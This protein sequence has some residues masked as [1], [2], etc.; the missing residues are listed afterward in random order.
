MDV[1]ALLGKL[2][3]ETKV[4]MLSG[5]DM[6]SLPEIP[7]IGLRRLVMS[8]GPIGVRG[9]AW[10]GEPSTTLPNPTALAATWD[11]ALAHRVGRLLAAEALAKGVH[12]LLA[13]TVNLH[14]SPLG[15][16]HFECYS[17]DPLLTGEIGAAFVTGVQSG[18]VAAAV[19]HFVANDSETERMTYDVRVSDRALRELYLAPFERIVR[20]GAWAVMAS[21][22]G[23]RGATLT[24]NAP[25]LRDIL[26]GEWG[27]DG[28][29]V[30]DW[31]ATRDTVRA[32]L[33]GLDIAMPGPHTVW[34]PALVAAVR[35]GRVPEST[36][37]DS[38]R[39]VLRLAERA[40]A[41]TP[42]QPE[43][44]SA[45][46]PAALAR[47]VAARSFVL[48]RNTGVLPIAT[49]TSR[50][51]VIGVPAAHPRFQ[52]GGS[53][54]LT[55]PYVVTPLDGLR[56][57]LPQADIQYVP[58]PDPSRA[59]PPAT[60]EFIVRY[61]A[62]DGTELHRASLLEASVLHI[63]DLPVESAKLAKV[64]VSGT[65]RAEMAGQW[66]VCARG[67]GQ[68]RLTVGE[69]V[70]DLTL[71]PTGGD[72]VEAF[73]LPPQEVVAVELTAR[74]SVPVE[75]ETDYVELMPG[76]PALAFTLGFASPERP[77]DELIA[78]A[79]A[80]ASAADVAIV[81]VGTTAENE[82]EGIDRA[83]ITLPGA[84]DALVA[85]VA[86][87]NPR[88]V[89]VVNAGAP[90]LV[91]WADDVAAV[92]LSWFGGQEFG[93]AL[94][95]TLTG[96]VEPGGR[97]PTTWPS[98]DAD[99]AVVTPVDGRLQ[100]TEDLAIGYRADPTAVAFP[101]GHGLGYTTW[102][103][104]D[105]HAEGDTF[106]VRL[107]NDGDRPGREIVQVYLS[108]DSGDGPTRW[109]AGFAAVTAEPGQTATATIELPERAFQIWTDAGW[110]RPEATYTVHI[111]HSVADSRVTVG[112]SPDE[113][114]EVRVGEPKARE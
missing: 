22:N 107:R 80:A 109:L 30:S 44:I 28:A 14:R 67:V 32:A 20:A 15:G 47:E 63:G 7:E 105:A 45:E 112:L 43:P 88:T 86:A 95:D 55:P 35:D 75:L 104:L 96:A 90:V 34:G 26:K 6:W 97:L 72:L 92:L 61:L 91:P 5:A 68:Y 11:P 29:V 85:A 111:G 76:F 60:G 50:I 4:R 41:L 24:E 51:A 77:D 54:Q 84:Q 103:Y 25:L 9:E 89:A 37:D 21:Y 12:V 101:F 83:T 2:D 73:L 48:M 79:V 16:R 113:G 57:A 99:P 110:T 18:R 93:N 38:V 49:G 114:S 102:S 17:E 70:H 65:V 19:K 78:D 8:D 64:V 27:F 62:A 10:D 59:L 81:V 82:S 69:D 100:Y 52:G 46:Q 42:H 94:A 31:L 36:V 87:A 106:T 66:R 1:E 56:A 98:A 71:T 39:R 13:P 33:G 74:Q 108:A 53:A 58:G 40:G 3:L 23:V